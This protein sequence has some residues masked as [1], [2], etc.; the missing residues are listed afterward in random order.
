MKW[1]NPATSNKSTR[2]I[3][4]I[5]KSYKIDVAVGTSCLK[6]FHYG[7]QQPEIA[8]ID[9][10]YKD[11]MIVKNSYYI[12]IYRYITHSS[13]TVLNNCLQTNNKMLTFL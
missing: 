4:V 12:Y 6:I 7:L 11:F 2:C 9:P 3:P 10:Q 8:L 5:S 1:M 13:L